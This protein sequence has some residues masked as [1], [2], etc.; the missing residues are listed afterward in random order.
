MNKHALFEQKYRHNLWR[1]DVSFYKG[2]RFANWRKWYLSEDGWRPTK[3]G[4]TFPVER[5]DELQASIAAYCTA[6][7]F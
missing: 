2:Q 6:E 3:E 4:C 1:L 5:L 7:G